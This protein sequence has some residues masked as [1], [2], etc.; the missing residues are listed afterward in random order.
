MEDDSNKNKILFRRVMRG[1]DMKAIKLRPYQSKAIEAIQNAVD[2]NQKHMVIEIPSGFDK[3]IIFVKAIE[4]LNELYKGKI[5]VVAGN[6]SLK[7]QVEKELFTKYQEFIQIDKDNILLE[8]ER[9]IIRNYSQK[10]EEYPIVI[11]YDTVMSKQIYEILSCKEKVVVAFSGIVHEN[12]KEIFSPESTVFAYTYQQAMKEGY[13]TPAMDA[14]AREFAFER[15]GEQLLGGFGYKKIELGSDADD[16]EW[17]L[18]MKKG[19]RRLLVDC[20]AYKSQVI[21]PSAAHSLLYAIVMK[22]KKQELLHKDV[23]LLLVSSKIPSLQKNEIYRRYG[24]VILDIENLVFYSNDSPT[25]LKLLSQITYFPIDHI[26]G[27]GLEELE[28]SELSETSEE[29]IVQDARKENEEINELIQCLTLCKGGQKNSGEYEKICERIIRTLFETNYFNRLTSQHK[30][31][32]KHF[33]MD[34][35]GALKIN[36]NNEESMHPLWQMLVQHYNS[37]FV[38]FEFKNYSKAIDQNLIYITEKYLFDAALRNVAIIISRKGFSE[39]AK[40]AAAGCLK[41]HGKLI[42]NI[43]DDDLIKMLELRSDK[44]ADYLLDKLEE[45]LMEISK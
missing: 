27:K 18:I 37:H 13:I 23:V 25:L 6:S 36:Q 38:V 45:F 31:K 12:L 40:F 17:D 7:E 32:D 16:N 9:Q 22:R 14:R 20:K 43:T 29:E 33:R 2:R 24:I 42:L 34:L 4:K 21:S 3:G 35:L 1:V 28:T 5:L 44:A 41:E 26:E 11:F 15:F 10:E 19:D 30:T 8:T 39:S